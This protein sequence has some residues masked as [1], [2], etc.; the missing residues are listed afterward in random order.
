MSHYGHFPVAVLHLRC[1]SQ[2]YCAPSAR[3]HA[4]LVAA[5]GPATKPSCSFLPSPTNSRDAAPR[6]RVRFLPEPR[7]PPFRRATEWAS[8]GN[9]PPGGGGGEILLCRR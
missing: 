9:I 6:H 4:Q 7:P 5:F 3:Q 8:C 1:L 2:R